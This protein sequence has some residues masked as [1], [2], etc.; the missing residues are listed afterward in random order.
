MDDVRKVILSDPL[1]SR[2]FGSGVTAFVVG[3]YVR[4][5]LRGV[6]SRDIDFVVVGDPRR[7][8]PRI[9]PEGNSII[10]FREN[11]LVRVVAGNTTADFSELRG[12]IR[13]DLLRRDF[14]VNAIGWSPGTGLVDPVKGVSD[15]VRGRLRG[16]S[17]KNFVNDPLRLLRAY[18]LSAELGWSVERKT[19]T[20]IKD[21]RHLMVMPAPERITLEFHKLLNAEGYLKALKLAWVHGILDNIISINSCRL[22][23]NIK[24]LS[25]L[26]AFFKDIPEEWRSELHKAFSQGLSFGG[27][28]RAERLL[29][30]A[31]LRRTRMRLSRAIVKRLTVSSRFLDLYEEKGELNDR[32][33][34][35]LFSLAGDSVI[36]FA[37]LTGKM[38]LLRKAAGFLQLHPLLAAEE[39]ME[40]SGLVAGPKLGRVL[41]T[42]KKMQ[43]LGKIRDEREAREWLIHGDPL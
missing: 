11:L 15:I 35:D 6:V 20:I 30:G 42:L 29:H 7:V 16:L 2:V 14:T 22:S 24:A 10:A 26:T 38:R 33:I 3:G 17:E 32:A 40:I 28:V 25:R 13:D 4:D 9:F 19:K 36:D 27:M 41:R 34:F 21:L 5:I 8:V 1:V 12:D 39:V 23:D 37:L 18:R 31:D 43:F